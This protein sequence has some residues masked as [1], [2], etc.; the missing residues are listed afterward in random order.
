VTAFTFTSQDEKTCLYCDYIAIAMQIILQQDADQVN[1]I[2]EYADMICGF[3][4]PDNVCHQ[5]VDK[6]DA[7]IDQLKQ[8]KHPRD[9]CV[10]LKYCTS[11]SKADAEPFQKA[12]TAFVANNRAV[13]IQD[14]KKCFYCDYVATLVQIIMQEDADQVNEIR[15]YA[16][17]ICGFLGPDNI[18]HQYVDKLDII[19]DQL[20]KGQHPREICTSLKYCTAKTK[21]LASSTH[22]VDDLAS[23]DQ[24]LVKIVK[25]SMESAINGCFVCTQLASILE[26]A[27][28][29][30]PS[31]IDQIRQI[32]DLVCG[33]LPS[34]S[35][36][37]P[38]M[39]ELDK[40]IDSLKKGEKPK[41]I[42]HDMKFCAASSSGLKTKEVAPPV[43]NSG[44]GN[45][46]CA[47]CSGVVTVLEFA[48][49]QNPGEV[50]EAREAAGIVCEL[51]PP[52]DK[53]HADLKMFDFAVSQLKSG[54]PPHEICQALK[55]CTSADEAASVKLSDLKFLDPSLSPSRC[56][57]CKQ[58]SLLLASMVAK[59]ASLAT[60][61]AEVNS[62]CRLIPDSKECTLLM[63]HHDTIVDALK[64]NENIESICARIH[65]CD[66][67]NEVAKP[68]ESEKSMS[69]GCLLCEYT[70][71]MV[72]RASKNQNELRLAK[73]A[74]ETMC[75]ILPPAARCDVLSSKSPSQACHSV[76][77][78]DAAFVEAPKIAEAIERPD[79]LL[80]AEFAP[81]AMGEVMELE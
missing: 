7:M 53:C 54:K 71:E 26:V 79:Y 37:R 30:D 31:Q 66:S 78:C 29:E 41:A 27:L 16:D 19:I 10:G 14:D 57:I 44:K 46:S 43:Q 20:K 74:L 56:T 6:F 42:C 75:T 36:C 24:H 63:K 2:R 8:G 18:C 15:E 11:K 9:I 61:T 52:D 76:A 47:Y 65:E 80:P 17:M 35:K 48:L 77:L 67:V 23:Y 21:A 4:G 38:V 39:D 3:L 64:N 22:G 70:A 68:V 51:R 62:I 72:S 28:A 55:F 5:Y 32:G 33:F 49:N 59:P 1:E 60:F 45:N 81:V 73:V 34:E 40:V 25:N 13:D 50:K 58:N 12:L 69:M